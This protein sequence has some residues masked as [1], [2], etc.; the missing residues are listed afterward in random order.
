[1][2]KKK[3]YRMS[4]IV[5]ERICNHMKH[6]FVYPELILFV[7]VH[8]HLLFSATW[9]TGRHVHFGKNLFGECNSPK[10]VGLH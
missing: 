3:S 7:E 10:K 9:V 2:I 6:L 1:M 5:T 8:F 4:N